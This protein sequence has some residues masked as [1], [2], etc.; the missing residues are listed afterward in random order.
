MFPMEVSNCNGHNLSVGKPWVPTT[1][2]APAVPTYPWIVRLGN[3]YKR[4]TS[5]E[6]CLFFNRPGVAGAV[7]QIP[8]LLIDSL[9]H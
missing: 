4:A 5:L 8:L 9:G 6:C 2:P 3:V 1:L 7:I